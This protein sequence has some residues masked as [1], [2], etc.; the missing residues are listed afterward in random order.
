MV[1]ILGKQWKIHYGSLM[2]PSERASDTA[3]QAS[4]VALAGAGRWDGHGR[5]IY[6]TRMGKTKIAI[7]LILYITLLHQGI[8]TVPLWPL[9]HMASST[10]C[11]TM[12]LA[13]FPRS[14]EY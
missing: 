9:A 1:G 5:E 14:I 11:S 4:S 3:R 2:T 10:S 8:H 13:P 12:G 7:A 6:W